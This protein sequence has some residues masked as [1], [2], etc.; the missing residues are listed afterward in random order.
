MRETS[1]QIPRILVESPALKP[2]HQISCWG[3]GG[4]S[5]WGQLQAWDLLPLSRVLPSDFM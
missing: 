1:F 2:G 3:V 5:F 4:L